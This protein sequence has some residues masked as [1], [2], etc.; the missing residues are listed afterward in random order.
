MASGKVRT[1]EF[2]S[3]LILL[4]KIHDSTY[5]HRIGGTPKFDHCDCC[6]ED[7]IGIS[8]CDCNGEVPVGVSG[9]SLSGCFKEVSGSVIADFNG[10]D[11]CR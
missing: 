5:P 11:D 10:C 4:I 3:E 8:D 2:K 7:S 9:Y 6:K 1:V